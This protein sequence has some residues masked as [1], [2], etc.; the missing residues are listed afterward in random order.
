MHLKFPYQRD[1]FVELSP[2]LWLSPRSRDRTRS[3]GSLLSGF[4]ATSRKSANL[5][6]ALMVGIL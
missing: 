4:L 5:D 6:T 1:K 3:F 2:V